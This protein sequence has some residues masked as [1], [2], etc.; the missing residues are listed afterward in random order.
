MRIEGKKWAPGNYKMNRIT[1]K[2]RRISHTINIQINLDGTIISTDDI[3][4]RTIQFLSNKKALIWTTTSRL[5][6]LY[7][8]EES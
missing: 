7:Q 6:L 4:L 2:I 3:Q 1:T 8:V 5:G